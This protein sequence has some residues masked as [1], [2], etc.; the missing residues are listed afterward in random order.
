[1]GVINNEFNDWIL[2][3]SCWCYTTRTTTIEELY[4]INARINA[5]AVAVAR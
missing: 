2:W 3:W 1:M 4:H 5:I